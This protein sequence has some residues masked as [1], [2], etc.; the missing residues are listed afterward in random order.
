MKP[1]AGLQ[2]SDTSVITHR[3][4]GTY[5]T[6]FAPNKNSLWQ[7]GTRT[8]I[9]VSWSI[10]VLKVP[11]P[12]I[13]YQNKS[14]DIAITFANKNVGPDFV[15]FDSKHIAVS[16]ATAFDAGTH[17]TVFYLK[18]A[19][20]TTWSDGTTAP[21][22]Y[23]WTIE[24]R[25]VKVPVLKNTSLVYNNQVFS[26][27]LDNFEDSAFIKVENATAIQAGITNH[28]QISLIDT[29]NTEWE[30]GTTAPKEVT[31]YI[32]ELLIDPP[33]VKNTVLPYTGKRQCP[34]ITD[35][36]LSWMRVTND[37]QILRNLYTSYVE[38]T[39]PENT[40]WKDTGDNMTREIPWEITKRVIPLPEIISDTTVIYDGQ[41][42]RMILAGNDG[43]TDYVIDEDY[44][45]D[46]YETAWIKIS[47]LSGTNPGSY[48]LTF[49]LKDP[50]NTKF[51]DSI[52]PTVTRSWTITKIPVLIPV[53]F[54]VTYTGSTQQCDFLFY[55]DELM[56]VEGDVGTN[57]SNYTATF[58]LHNP[59]LYMW[60]TGSSDFVNVP[61]T[62]TPQL[63]DPG[64]ALLLNNVTWDFDNQEHDY[65]TGFRMPDS[66]IFR[67]S[68]DIVA[69]ELGVY[70]INI[71]LKDPH[72][73]NWST[74]LP[75]TAP[76]TYH[77]TIRRRPVAVPVLTKNKFTYTG[78]NIVITKSFFNFPVAQDKAFVSLEDGG[79]TGVDAGTYT[80]YL[81]FGS[82]QSSCMWEDTHNMEPK[83]VSW[84]IE[85]APLPLWRLGQYDITVPVQTDN[86]KDIYVIREG[87][88]AV[89]A[90]VDN[91]EAVRIRVFYANASDAKVRIYSKGVAG[92][93][94]VTVSVNSGRNYLSSA[95]SASDNCAASLFCTV[96]VS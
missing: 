10:T 96:T 38:L 63:I 15:N 82:F 46:T 24:K 23:S 45:K 8:P 21:I 14:K 59:D 33:T 43:I 65:F 94:V 30:D 53:P 50:Y 84:T 42:H 95:D 75:A 29:T 37:K 79:S 73:Y 35:V 31:W 93:A 60:Q 18:D 12:S 26:V 66:K 83:P 56:S 51:P 3:N 1:S 41:V 87:N 74:S 32:S 55:D 9:T 57:V 58:N 90:S 71:F 20:N 54:D 36:N 81:T 67:V 40:K 85:K 86:Y 19:G 34:D 89:V 4:T 76:V 22:S 11:K 68:G 77:M 16:A 44:D 62:I 92:T 69:K 70:D 52:N 91:E 39:S 61:W 80:A 2:N 49:T 17:Y 25:K 13:K 27:T 5:K 28:T 64:R 48:T 47:G 72:N 6:R 88:G 7:D 78:S